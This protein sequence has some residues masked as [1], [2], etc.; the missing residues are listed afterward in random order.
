MGQLNNKK[1]LENN[2]AAD[3]GTPLFPVLADLYL[4]TKDLRRARKVCEL[5]LENDPQ[6]TDGKFILA[7]VEL[8][9]EKF[10]LAEKWL[11]QV[12]DGNPLHITA[13]RQLIKLEF[14]LKRSYNTIQQYV[15]RILKFIPEDSECAGWISLLN[16]KGLENDENILENQNTENPP[17]HNEESNEYRANKPVNEPDYAVVPSMATFTMVKILRSQKHY[18]QALATLGVLESIGGNKDRISK[19]KEEIEA[20][21]TAEEK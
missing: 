11:K 10:T 16:E 7:K 18:H 15:N 4:K 21:L 20:L 1:Y 9:A 13:L 19:D 3:F 8:V 14:H 2:F 5:G 12:V 17:N 6:N